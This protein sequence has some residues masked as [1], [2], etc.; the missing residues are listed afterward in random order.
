MITWILDIKECKRSINLVQLKMKVVELTQT[1]L[2]ASDIG[3]R[4]NIHK[5]AFDEQKDWTLA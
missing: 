3:S 2:I 5:L 4:E 1:K